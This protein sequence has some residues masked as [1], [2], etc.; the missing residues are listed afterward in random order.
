MGPTR[1]RGVTMRGYLRRMLGNGSRAPLTW[2]S[3]YAP[4]VN[5]PAATGWDGLA[6]V[7]AAVGWRAK[8]WF[9]SARWRMAASPA[10]STAYLLPQMPQCTMAGRSRRRNSSCSWHTWHE[11]ATR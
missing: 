5:G 9:P 2:G 7:G 4:Y 11:N 1:G 10:V 6:G 8:A 3:V